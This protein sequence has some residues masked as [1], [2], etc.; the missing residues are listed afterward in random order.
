MHPQASPLRR[1]MYGGNATF[2]PSREYRF[3]SM[4]GF[5]RQPALTTHGHVLPNPEVRVLVFSYM[6]SGT[7]VRARRKA[8]RGT[9][10][11]VWLA[12]ETWAATR[13]LL[14]SPRWVHAGA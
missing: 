3:K 1:P 8:K 14:V 4:Y 2:R 7:L 13:G 5:Q 6:D 11:G 12:A 10:W 9:R